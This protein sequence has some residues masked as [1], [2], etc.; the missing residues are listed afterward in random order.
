MSEPPATTN[1]IDSSSSRQ[2]DKADT[3]STFY[4][5]G[6]RSQIGETT[7]STV[8]SPLTPSVPPPPPLSSTLPR[9]VSLIRGSPADSTYGTQVRVDEPSDNNAQL[10]YPLSDGTDALNLPPLVPVR[11]PSQSQPNIQPRS[12]AIPTPVAQNAFT[13]V[14]RTTMPANSVVPQKLPWQYSQESYRTPTAQTPQKYPSSRTYGNTPVSFPGIPR[15]PHQNMGSNQAVKPQTSRRADTLVIA[16]PFQVSRG[17]A[18]SDGLAAG[19]VSG[20]QGMVTSPHGSLTSRPTFGGNANTAPPSG[21]YR[22]GYISTEPGNYLPSHVPRHL[23]QPSWAPEPPIQPQTPFHIPSIPVIGG[24]ASGQENRSNTHMPSALPTPIS[25]PPVQPQAPVLSESPM[26]S[27]PHSPTVG[28][29]PDDTVTPNGPYYTNWQEPKLTGIAFKFMSITVPRQMYLY[30]LFRLPSLYF[31]RVGKIFEE[32]NISVGETKR[33]ALQASSHLLFEPSAHEKLT[34]SWE[35][36]I[37]SVTEEWKTFNV[38]STLLLAFVI[39]PF[40]TILVL[41]LITVSNHIGPF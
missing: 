26:A 17:D 6:N 38:V 21:T 10:A 25:E 13:P 28:L 19:S 40:H 39:L 9:P 8:V 27:I 14:S 7:T 15:L 16:D 31:S 20:P 33:I 24:E 32:A 2:V 22:Q 35:F 34:S 4:A 37:G 41:N 12:T 29:K 5:T 1:R 18:C 23:K 11:R 3:N 36:F 30:I